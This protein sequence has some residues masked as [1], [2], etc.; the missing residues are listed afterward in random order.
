MLTD[1]DRALLDRDSHPEAHTSAYQVRTW[2]RTAQLSTS[3]TTH[4]KLH[5]YSRDISFPLCGWILH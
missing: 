4:T 1:L 3:L 5:T 2:R